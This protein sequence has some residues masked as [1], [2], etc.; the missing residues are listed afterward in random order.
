MKTATLCSLFL[1]CAATSAQAQLKKTLHKVFEVP[2]VTQQLVFNIYEGDEYEVVPWA[3]NTIL[4]ETQIE[5]YNASKGVFDFFLKEGRYDFVS[6]EQ[7]DSLIL[8]SK[9][10]LRHAIKIE[11]IQSEERVVS[12]IF[13]PDTFQKQGDAL[14]ARPETEKP[15]PKLDRERAKAERPSPILP[16]TSQRK[17]PVQD[18]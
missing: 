13:V 8:S 15:E 10:L 2:A 5:M 14:W 16:D 7:S 6:L 1:L 17:P 4:T 11:D 12:R 18:Q 3:G 9:D